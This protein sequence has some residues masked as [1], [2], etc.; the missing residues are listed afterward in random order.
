MPLRGEVDDWSMPSGGPWGF[1]GSTTRSPRSHA[2]RPWR[3]AYR[4]RSPALAGTCSGSPRSPQGSGSASLRPPTPAPWR[5]PGGGRGRSRNAARIGGRWPAPRLTAV[6][7]PAP[8]VRDA[9]SAQAPFPHPPCVYKGPTRERVR[10]GAK[11]SGAPARSSA[12]ES[13]VSHNPVI[14]LH[15]S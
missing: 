1:P 5:G 4:P 14:V 3:S 8:R 15:T 12:F 13:L 10:P 6:V 7:R 9:A 11:R 2:G